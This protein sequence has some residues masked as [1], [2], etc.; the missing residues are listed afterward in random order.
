MQYVLN[1]AQIRKYDRLATDLC[2]VPS[3]ILME[4][5][6]RG[7]ADIVAD[8]YAREGNGITCVIVCGTGNNGGDG[9]VVARHLKA[10][11]IEPGVYLI[12]ERTRISQDAKINYEA[13]LAS[14][15]KC[16]DAGSLATGLIPA[17]IIVDALFGTGLSRDIEGAEADAIEIINQSR[18]LRISLDIPS[19]LDADTGAVLG[20]AIRANHTIT[21]AHAK[22]GLYTPQG[23]IHCGQI[24]T[25]NLGVPDA[26]ILD[27]TGITA[28]LLSHH[29]IRQSF[30]RRD[31]TTYK[32]KAGDVLVVAGSTGKTGA[33]K[34]VA[35]ATLRAG[36]GLAT[37]CTWP[38]TMPAFEK[39]L[40]EIMLSP[41]NTAALDESLVRAMSKRSSIVVGPGL[42]VSAE[43]GQALAYILKH[44]RCPVVVDADAITLA[45][46]DRDMLKQ[47]GAEKFLTP[48]SGEL[49]RLMGIT[50]AEIE[51]DRF[52]ATRRAA[53]LCA[54]IIVLKGAH[55]IIATPQGEMFVCG[56]AN[57]VLATAGSGDVLAG[58]IGAFAATMP[59]L[60]AACAGVYVHAQAGNLWSEKHNSDRGMLAGDLV[61][62]LPQLIG[63][64]PQQNLPV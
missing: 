46:L 22:P 19:G 6:G 31:A 29:E 3:L 53:E 13:L 58:I 59:P 60:E 38:E 50:S 55:T 12:G 24:H 40:K 61:D 51:A 52:S 34:L 23:R 25:V 5:A 36:A 26:E 35:E 11:G 63:K 56:E 43:A 1:R 45:A 8:I 37:I 17:G 10:R 9:F 49:A 20:H 41:L 21:F 42:G 57:P 64:L 32:H 15:I 62:L 16:L 27:K 28:R 30:T 47:S 48:H 4:N 14:G 44:A 33:A 7:A 2:K 54:S 18:A 39:E